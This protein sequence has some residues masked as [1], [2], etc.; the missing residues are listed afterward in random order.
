MTCK[1]AP[2]AHVLSV[3]SLLITIFAILIALVAQAELKGGGQPSTNAIVVVTSQDAGPPLFLPAVPYDTGGGLPWSVA[4]GD[5]N[6]DGKPDLVVV[7]YGLSTSGSVGVLLGNGDGTFQPA[8]AYGS[9]GGGPSGIAVSDLN[10]D[11]KLDLVVANQGCPGVSSNCL[12]VLLGN[13]NGTFQAV[14]I[15]PD[16][17]ADAAG[18]E[19]I[20]IPIM[21]AD[22]NGDGKPDLV[23]VSQTNSNSVN[24][25]V[26][27]LLGNGDGT[28]K[29]VVTYDAGGVAAFS[30]VL[31]D[32]NSDG[33]PDLVGLSC[34][35]SGL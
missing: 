15:Y 12:G 11:G 35:P 27:V 20:F 23:V 5:F 1:R 9:G 30:G 33:K 14:V 7:N 22:V 6:G 32:V 8:V 28:F 34:G 16:G 3:V 31:A 10:G 26:G 4:V 25:L 17:G 21:I 13:G 18:G 29:P 2:K 24:A 19:G